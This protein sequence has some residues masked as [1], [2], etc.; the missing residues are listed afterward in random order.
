MLSSSVLGNYGIQMK[1]TLGESDTVAAT[2]RHLSVPAIKGEVTKR[3]MY[4]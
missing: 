4:M 2:V 3:R 1:G